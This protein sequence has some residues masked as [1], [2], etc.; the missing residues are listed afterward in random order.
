MMQ[1]GYGF[2]CNRKLVTVFSAP[3][4]NPETNNMGAVMMIDRN[5]KAHFTLLYP[6][7]DGK[8]GNLF[9]FNFKKLRIL[10]FSGKASESIFKN[11]FPTSTWEHYLDIRHIELKDSPKFFLV[12]K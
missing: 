4:Y 5:M 3:R 8:T 6:S 10:D 7:P 9:F 12:E 11:L 1:N 2:Y